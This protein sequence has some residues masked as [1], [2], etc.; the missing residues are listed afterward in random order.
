MEVI[1]GNQDSFTSFRETRG[2]PAEINI[3]LQ[4]TELE[5][6]TNDRIG[7]DYKDSF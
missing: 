4:F 6:M 2:A 7:F 1:Y 3:R 5:T